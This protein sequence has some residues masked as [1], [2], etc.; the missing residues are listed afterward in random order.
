MKLNIE[1]TEF[2]LFNRKMD[3]EI[4]SIAIKMDGKDV[5]D[6]DVDNMAW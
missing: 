4:S 3:N 1:K 6:I 2:C 5:K